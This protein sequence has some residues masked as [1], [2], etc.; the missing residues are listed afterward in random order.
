MKIDFSKEEF[1]TL[2]EMIDIASWIISARK[3]EH[4]AEEKPYQDMQNK[5][6][7]LAADFGCADKVEFLEEWNEYCASNYFEMESPHRKFIDD[8]DEDAFWDGLTENL[9]ARDAIRE[10]GKEK[11][12]GLDPLQR[13]ELI[14]EHESKWAD[15]FSENGLENIALITSRSGL[16]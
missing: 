10:V 12:L 14:G 9:A 8:Y 3:S 1:V 5:L 7:S 2:I 4:G 13:F 11:F 15:E 6:F 16:Q